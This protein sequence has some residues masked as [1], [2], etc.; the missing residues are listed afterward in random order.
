MKCTVVLNLS[1]YS[2]KDMQVF[3]ILLFSMTCLVC[4]FAYMNQMFGIA[5][6]TNAFTYTLSLSQGFFLL[7]ISDSFFLQFSNQGSELKELL[8]DKQRLQN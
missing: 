3:R 5:F 6:N 2:S 4:S 7:R 8:A 1:S